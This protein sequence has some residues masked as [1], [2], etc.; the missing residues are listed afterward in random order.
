M[1]AARGGVVRSRDGARQRACGKDAKCSSV[2]KACDMTIFTVADKGFVRLR[3][4]SQALKVVRGEGRTDVSVKVRVLVFI[5]CN[6]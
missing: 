1:P 4:F 6:L 2:M 3:H 5:S